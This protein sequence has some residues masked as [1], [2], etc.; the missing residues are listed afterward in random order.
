MIEGNNRNPVFNYKRHHTVE[1]VT[2]MLV[3]YLM[4]EVMTFRVY[5]FADC[6][7]KN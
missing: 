3:D 7:P 5:G 4:K 1:V 2:K 6:K